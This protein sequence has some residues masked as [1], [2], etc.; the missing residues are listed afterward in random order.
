MAANT[1]QEA[2]NHEAT[3]TGT[4][5]FDGLSPYWLSGSL[6]GATSGDASRRLF[7]AMFQFLIVEPL[8]DD[9][10]TKCSG[11]CHAGHSVGQ[12]LVVLC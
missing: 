6:C 4:T 2:L 12:Q 10:S 8:H 7:F 1:K 11:N 3:N 5:Y 9:G